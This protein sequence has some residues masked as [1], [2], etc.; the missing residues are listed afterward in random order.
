MNKLSVKGT[1]TIC[2]ALTLLTFAS[3]NA[4]ADT[5]VTGEQQVPAVAD[6]A[7]VPVGEQ[8]AATVD[9]QITVVNPV[10]G[11]KNVITQTASP[12]PVGAD[13][14][15]WQVYFPPV[16]QGYK[17]SQPFVPVTAVTPDTQASKVEITYRPLKQG[18]IRTNTFAGIFF[19]DIHGKQVGPMLCQPVDKQGIVQMP[20]APKGWE[21]IN[22][23][24]LPDSFLCY[25][26]RDPF[27]LF[28]VRE[29]GEQPAA[30][31]QTKQL[32]R[33]I[34]CHLPE[35]DKVYEQTVTAKKVGDSPWSVPAFPE[36]TVPVPTGYRPSL[37]AV[38]AQDAAPSQATLTVEVTYQAITPALPTP[39]GRPDGDRQPGSTKD[40]QA[41]GSSLANSG[42]DET[43]TLPGLQAQLDQ[44]Q[45]PLAQLENNEQA[46]QPLVLP[47]T[48][49]DSG[50]GLSAAGL[51]VAAWTALLG[52]FGLKKKLY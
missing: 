4:L 52:M 20:A 38:P 18:D 35:G 51:M 36:F 50:T 27:Y 41:A 7:A 15:I 9:R 11:E 46:G 14:N 10:S 17:P 34:I 12:E 25:D 44:L 47:Q 37:K 23:E 21:Y 31:T 28:L 30:S 39:P 6:Q 22:R 40:Q 5:A 29:I 13:T 42:H 45:A 3:T 43:A 16:Y 48:G 49:D 32:T 33:K 26:Y 8:R 1:L 24:L 19:R 2:T